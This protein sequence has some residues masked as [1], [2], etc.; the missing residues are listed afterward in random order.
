MNFNVYYLMDFNFYNLFD[1][2]GVGLIYLYSSPFFALLILVEMLFSHFGKKNLYTKNDVF[3]NVIFA[4]FNFALDL[5]MKSFAFGVM[6]FFF[7]HRIVS[8][9]TQIWYYWAAVFLLQDFAYYVLHV[10][11]HKSRFFWSVHITHHSSEYYNISTGFRSPVFQPLYR[12]LYFS[13]LAFLGFN[14]WHIMAAYALFQVYGTLVHTQSVKTMGIFEWILV[15][16][17]HH[18]VHHARNIKYLD[19]NMGMALII[20]D[21]IFGTFQKEEPEIPVKFGIYPKPKN[22]GAFENLFYEWKKMWKD[23]KQPGIGWQNRLKYIF[24]APGWKPN[25]Q[26]K[27][28]KDYQREYQLKQN[29]ILK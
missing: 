1:E 14:P 5:I 12:Y 9:N 17:S 18:R 8:W 24:Y 16:P 26:G 6:F 3:V 13:P 11:D 29:S 28:V 27:T 19:K 25:G 2:N 4:V 10:V 15:T 22:D 20:W 23:I 21:R 7:Q